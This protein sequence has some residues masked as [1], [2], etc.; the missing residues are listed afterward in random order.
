VRTRDAPGLI[1]RL[2][3]A[4][5]SSQPDVRSFAAGIRRDRGA[6]DA[7]LISHWSAA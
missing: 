7:A 5:A 3:Q 4:D 6:I 1:A 2:E